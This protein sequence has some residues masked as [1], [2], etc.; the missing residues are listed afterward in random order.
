MIWGSINSNMCNKHNEMITVCV[1]LINSNICNKHNEI[2][3]ACVYLKNSTLSNKHNEMITACV[4]EKLYRI[5]V[6]AFA[7]AD[8]AV[9]MNGLSPNVLA[10]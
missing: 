5:F 4:Y 10:T 2:I 9:F 6:Q 3:T 7:S 1:Y 8:L